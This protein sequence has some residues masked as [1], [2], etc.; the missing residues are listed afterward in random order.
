MSVHQI[1]TG[2]LNDGEFAFSVGCVDGHKF[3]VRLLDSISI[4]LRSSGM[5]SWRQSRYSHSKLCSHP[6]YSRLSVEH[7][8]CG[9]LLQRYGQSEFKYRFL[10][11]TNGMLVCFRLHFRRT[12]KCVY[13]NRRSSLERKYVIFAYNSSGVA[14]CNFRLFRT[15]G[16]MRTQLRLNLTLI[17]SNGF[18]KASDCSYSAIATWL[19]ISIASSRRPSRTQTSERRLSSICMTR[20]VS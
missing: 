3:I 5:R 6:D 11:K 7:H 15:V 12:T 13:L 1:L 17:I 18:L 10:T 9:Q 4:I 16:M 2:A 8:K 19:S 20:R 14:N